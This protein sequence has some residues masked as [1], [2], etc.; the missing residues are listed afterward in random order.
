MALGAGLVDGNQGAGFWPIKI[1][2]EDDAGS[3]GKG[4]ETGGEE[5]AGHC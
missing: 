1:G 4:W 5:A 2:R 3:K